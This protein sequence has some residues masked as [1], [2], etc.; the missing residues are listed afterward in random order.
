MYSQM[1]NAILSFLRLCMLK[2][3]HDFFISLFVDILF[4]SHYNRTVDSGRGFMYYM[5]IESLTIPAIST[6]HM[7]TRALFFC[8]IFF[9]FIDFCLFFFFSFCI[10]RG[11][12][13]CI[14]YFD[15]IWIVTYLT[16]HKCAQRRYTHMHTQRLVLILAVRRTAYDI[17]GTS[18][19]NCI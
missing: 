9:N 8:S 5:F 4:A 10:V 13:V 6:T 3:L 12:C 17:H 18:I 7:W 16:W 2:G 14:I 1:F 15:S 19:L 11:V